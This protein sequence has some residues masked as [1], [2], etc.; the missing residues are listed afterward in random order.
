M[1]NDRYNTGIYSK[2]NSK[3]HSHFSQWKGSGVARSLRIDIIEDQDNAK[4]QRARAFFVAN[5]RSG[6]TSEAYRDT[7]PPVEYVGREMPRSLNLYR[8]RGGKRACMCAYPATKTKSWAFL[9]PWRGSF[10][11]SKPKESP[12]EA[13]SLPCLFHFA[14]PLPPRV[15]RVLQH[16]FSALTF[17]SL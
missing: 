9:S 13:Y 14:P 2:H 1:Y 8:R 5:R 6:T 15:Y 4:K 17:V 16:S 11:F 7:L 3:F 12:A 10:T